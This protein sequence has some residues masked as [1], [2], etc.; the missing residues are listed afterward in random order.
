MNSLSARLRKSSKTGA[1][2]LFKKKKTLTGL[3]RTC[4]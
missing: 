3:S 2:M 1:T 4:G